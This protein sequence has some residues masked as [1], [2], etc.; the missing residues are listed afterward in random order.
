MAGKGPSRVPGERGSGIPA[1]FPQDLFFMIVGCEDEEDPEG[2]PGFGR[3]LGG[4]LRWGGGSDLDRRRWRCPFGPTWKCCR[5]ADVLG[6]GWG[7]MHTGASALRGG[8]EKQAPQGLSPALPLGG[9]GDEEEK[10]HRLRSSSQGDGRTPG[11]SYKQVKTGPQCTPRCLS[12]LQLHF[13]W[14]GGAALSTRGEGPGPGPWQV[15]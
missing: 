9:Q 1:V 8:T 7:E 6:R 14:G 13:L 2:L 3:A 11:S 15:P 12:E 5:W 4:M 10:R